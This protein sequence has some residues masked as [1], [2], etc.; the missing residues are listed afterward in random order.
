[1]AASITEQWL[2]CMQKTPQSLDLTEHLFN[3]LGVASDTGTTG[4]IQWYWLD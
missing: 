3:E 2:I 4:G 1:M